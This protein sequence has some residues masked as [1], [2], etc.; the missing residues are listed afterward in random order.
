MGDAQT[1]IQRLVESNALREPLLRTVIQALQLPQGSRGLDA[2]CGVGLQAALLAEAAGPDGRVTGL[3]I[4]PDLL[5]YAERVAQERGLSDRISFRAGAIEELPFDD[6]AFDWAWS[7]DCAGYPAGELLPALQEL[8][9]VVKPGGTVAVLAWSA[10]TLLPGYPLLEARLNAASSAYALYVQNWPPQSQFLRALHWL[11]AAGLQNVQARTFVEDVQAPLRP[12][13][14]I[15]LAALFSML[16][17]ATMM[18]QAPGDKAEYQRLC[19]AESPDFLPDLPDYYA[20]FT[21][22]MFQGRVAR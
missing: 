6:G 22:T 4:A 13:V 11:H 20:F 2:G 8:A 15:A 19:R 21:Y 16:W 7:A 17:D 1:Y 9:R 3:D 12:G 18:E 10:Q 5:R 14:R